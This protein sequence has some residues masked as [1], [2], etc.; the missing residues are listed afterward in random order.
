MN[1]APSEIVE[2][3]LVR[4][5]CSMSSRCVEENSARHSGILVM[6]DVFISYS[7][8]D[9]ALAEDLASFLKGCGYE[10][11][12]D[13]SLVAGDRFDDEIEK[14]LTA[15]RTVIVIWTPNSA[16]SHWVREEARQGLRDHKLIATRV[17][18]LTPDR[19]LSL[20]FRSVQTD[21]FTDRERIL[22][23]LERKGVIPFG[24]G[25]PGVGDKVDPAMIERAEQLAHWSSIKDSPA[26]AKFREYL[27]RYPT[28]NLAN[29]VRT[30]LADMEQAA[31]NA[32]PGTDAG[33]SAFLKDYP[34]GTFASEARR[35]L[36]DVIRQRHLELEAARE[37]QR[38]LDQEAAE[39]RLR[40]EQAA[41]RAAAEQRA[42][43]T[44]EWNAVA[45][46][47]DVAA[48]EAFLRVWPDGA[49][50]A[51]AKALL[52]ELGHADR[53]ALLIGAVT[54]VAGSAVAVLTIE[55]GMPIWRLLRDSSIRTFTGHS[56]GINSV[57]FSPNG[58][59][60]L[61]GSEDSTLKLWD[62]MTG[63]E[64][65]TLSGHSRT[66]GAVAFAPDGRTALSG[67]ED[68]TLKL[69]NV[70]T[71]E[72]LRTFHGHTAG[73]RM[74]AFMPDG[75]TALSAGDGLKLWDIATGERLRNVG[76]GGS[77]A[78]APDGRRTL[79][80]GANNIYL[81]DVATW[82]EL[83][84]FVGHLGRVTAVA[85]APDGRTALSASLDKT[86]KLW[87]VEP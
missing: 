45:G 20:D 40:T 38:R 4:H 58:K 71:G 29:L 33:L 34:N 86:L 52:V 65:R 23:A 74:V 79:S 35:R 8:K 47:K 51:D 75:R 28:A 66:V 2:P 1:I 84:T 30:R 36:D 55:P 46:S 24:G 37:R 76:V 7:S 39:Q 22:R 82:R 61:S 32:A 13:T 11:W 42:K 57:A 77:F 53:R 15:A 62:V 9:R 17:E 43:E 68:M 16:K 63:R 49:R 10:V 31:W 54:V 67:S 12:W 3:H 83:Y 85:F 6:A 73:I 48:I 70:G 27:D 5:Y 87:D 60:A 25:R 69:W 56:A 78:L 80:V 14:E 81:L 18:A 50:T 26:P 21:L 41:E 44:A 72:M 59:N 64:V 19:D